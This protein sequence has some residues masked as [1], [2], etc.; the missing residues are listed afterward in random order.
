MTKNCP[1]RWTHVEQIKKG[2]EIMTV[3]DK[4]EKK[5]VNFW[6]SAAPGSLVFVAGTFNN[7]DPTANPMHDQSG[8]GYFKTDMLVSPG[9]HEYKFVINGVWATDPSCQKRV[10]NTFGSENCV[11]QIAKTEFKV[12]ESAHSGKTSGKLEKSKDVE[13]CRKN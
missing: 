13:L 2:V 8:K 11:L 1:I 6:I 9:R 12:S 10:P 7:W 3:E 4:K 5:R